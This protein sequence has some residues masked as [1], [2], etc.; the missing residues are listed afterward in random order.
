MFYWYNINGAAVIQQ[1]ARLRKN[2][3]R[4]R[5]YRRIEFSPNITYFKPQGVP[6]RTLEIIELSADEVEALRLKNIEG[7]DQNKCAKKMGISQSTFQRTLSSAYKKIS[8]ALI[9]GKAIRIINK[10]AF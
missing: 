8:E 6:M 3:P 9:K 2:M 10:P 1:T 7:L 4:P 5:I